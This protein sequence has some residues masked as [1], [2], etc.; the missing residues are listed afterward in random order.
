MIELAAGLYGF[1]TLLFL[2][3]TYLEGERLEA[4][5]DVWRVAGLLLCLFWPTF[6]LAVLAAAA[7]SNRLVSSSST[8]RID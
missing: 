6:A 8:S 7:W 5:W 4:R 2:A 1:V 3:E